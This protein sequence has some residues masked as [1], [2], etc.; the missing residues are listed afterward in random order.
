MRALLIVV[1]CCIA[2]RAHAGGLYL[3]DRGARPLSRGGAFIAGA[4]DPNALWYN[5]AGLADSGN[6]VLADAT[7]TVLLASYQ[8]SYADGTRSPTVQASR[9]GLPI[10]T[11]AFSHDFGFKDI[12]FGGGIF[13]PNAALLD[14]PRSVREGGVNMPAPTRY[15]LISLRGS[16][17]SNLS[18]GA[19]WHGIEG[20]S[21]GADVQ[22]VTG[23]FKGQV[24]LSACGDGVV[25]NFPEDPSFD[26][27][28]TV[29]V[30]P[31]YGFTGVLGAKYTYRDV[32][33][34]GAS[35]VFP[36]TLRGPAKLSAK[37]PRDNPI[38]ENASIHG[39]RAD[40][41]MNFP[42]TLRA[43]IE[44]RP[45]RA[46]RSELAFVWEQW[47]TQ[48]TIDVIP[49]SIALRGIRGVGDYQLGAVSLPRSMKDSWSIRLG[50]EW[51]A[52]EHFALRG[53]IAYETGAFDEHT[54]TPLTLDVDKLVLSGGFSVQLNE[55]LTFDGSAGWFHMRD[56]RVTDSTIE[57]PQALRPA[58]TADSTTL[59]NGRYKVEAF[60]LGGGFR[61]TL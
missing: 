22:V 16:L 9:G 33:R 13:A 39:D 56:M 42:L 35:L 28:S 10:P 29:D 19:A 23:R 57:R 32:L 2:S 53:G 34:V 8:R 3:L 18:F 54:L 46:L 40:L 38:L 61:Y 36:Y 14:W 7:L 50:S 24:A 49:R 52:S 58:S 41:R 4:D 30:I 25:C 1:V 48:R 43:G 47:S 15:S 27:Y 55:Q 45:W 5:P 21:L 31:A 12:T 60:Y 17:L 6:Q 37:L 26:A 59:G 51:F 20:L 11:L 44:V